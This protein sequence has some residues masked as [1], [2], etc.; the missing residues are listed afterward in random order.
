M[1]EDRQMLRHVWE[2][3]V[4]VS[5]TVVDEDLKVKSLYSI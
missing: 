5:I 3:R 2:G 1:P 4:A